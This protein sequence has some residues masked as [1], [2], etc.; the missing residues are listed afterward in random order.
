MLLGGAAD[1][2][3]LGPACSPA[4][5]AATPAASISATIRFSIKSPSLSACA[6]PGTTRSGTART[7]TIPSAY[8]SGFISEAFELRQMIEVVARQQADDRPQLLGTPLGMECLA[9]EVFRAQ[10]PKKR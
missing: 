10:P 2:A 4:A 5:R 6:P 8:A 9:V 1:A 7:G 3:G